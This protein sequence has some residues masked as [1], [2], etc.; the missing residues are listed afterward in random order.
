MLRLNLNM[1]PPTRVMGV[2]HFLWK[3]EREE[4]VN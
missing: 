3:L 2:I 4:M 1:A